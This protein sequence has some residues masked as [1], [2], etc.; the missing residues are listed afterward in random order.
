MSFIIILGIGALAAAY[1]Y[2]PD[3]SRDENDR[4]YRP[5]AKRFQLP[6]ISETLFNDQAKMNY[7]C[8]TGL[9]VTN[10][11]LP[12]NYVYNNDNNNAVVTRA[13]MD[14]FGGPELKNL[15]TNKMSEY[16]QRRF[17]KHTPREQHPLLATKYGQSPEDVFMETF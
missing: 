17:E 14:T 7:F 6:A 11:T 15:S 16:L 13:Y 3:Y 10:L 9:N 1:L 4:S 5:F 2:K 8:N 12:D